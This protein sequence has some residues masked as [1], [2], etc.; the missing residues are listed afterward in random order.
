MR[1]KF[2]SEDGSPST[3]EL[4][5]RPTFYVAGDYRVTTLRIGPD[6]EGTILVQT[7]GLDN[8]SD[9]KIYLHRKTCLNSACSIYRYE[10]REIPGMERWWTIQAAIGFFGEELSFFPPEIDQRMELRQIDRPGDFNP[11]DFYDDYLGQ[12]AARGG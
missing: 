12:K 10:T 7:V 2:M 1:R 4:G 6:D 9:G 3:P 11:Q 5:E 8:D